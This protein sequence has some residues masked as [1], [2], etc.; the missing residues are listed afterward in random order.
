M[1]HLWSTF[2]EGKKKLLKTLLHYNPLL[3]SHT[4]TSPLSGLITS[5]VCCSPPHFLL[6][7]YWSGEVKLIHIWVISLFKTTQTRNKYF[8]QHL[9]SHN[10]KNVFSLV[11]TYISWS[12]L[13]LPTPWMMKTSDSCSPTGNTELLQAGQNL[14]LFL[15]NYRSHY[16][17]PTSSERWQEISERRLHPRGEGRCVQQCINQHQCLY[18][19]PATEQQKRQWLCFIF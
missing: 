19:V 9:R 15:C 10:M 16:H 17:S 7:S 6:L 8:Q 18:S 14:L 11:S 3:F 2:T 12:F 5:P 1:K 4:N 13:S